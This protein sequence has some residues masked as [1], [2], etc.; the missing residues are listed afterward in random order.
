MENVTD[1]LAQA[2]RERLAVIHN[3]ESRR[4]EARHIVRLKE[5]SERIE[6]LR[7][8]LPKP[9]DPRLA[10]YRERCSYEKALAYLETNCGG[11][12]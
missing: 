12:L 11:G 2:L 4:D 8:R 9:I 3:H 7:A 10:H 1:D 6:N 5:I